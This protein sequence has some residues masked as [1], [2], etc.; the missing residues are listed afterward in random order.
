MTV[1]D[2]NTIVNDLDGNM[3]SGPITN[4]TLVAYAYD[5]RNR[6]LNVGGVTNT[7]D[8]M[9]NRIGQTYGTNSVAYTINPNSSLPQLLMRIKNGVTNYYVYGAGLLYQVTESAAATNTLTYHYDYR[10]STVALTDGTGTNV[11]DQIEYSAYATMT[12]RT[13]TNDTPFLFNGRYGVM[14][15]PN[16][17]LYM[18]ARYYNPYI[19]RFVNPDPSGF[20]GG[21]NFYA[22][23]NGNPVSMVDPGGLD[24]AQAPQAASWLAN[25]I[26]VNSSGAPLNPSN[27]FSLDIPE[28]PP[29]TGQLFGNGLNN[30]VTAMGNTVGLALYPPGWTWQNWNQASAPLYSMDTPAN[31]AA[32][33]YVEGALGVSGG[34]TALAGGIG[35][36]GAVGLPT[37][38]VAV[39]EGGFSLSP[40]HAAYGVGDTWVNAVGNS[41]FKMTVSGAGAAD[42]VAAPYFTVTGIPVLFPSA[43]TTTGIP[44]WSCVTA[45]SS[46]L[47]RG[48]GL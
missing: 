29:T 45:A 38:N 13:G 34:A 36:W 1:I 35:L 26:G 39:G 32:T 46:A 9:N 23:G 22:Y 24:A 14:T 30:T 17:L 19:C 37:M 33:P 5:A 44:A 31:P 21:L 3:T 4:D 12:I 48:W 11:T 18:R 42:T 6:L 7:Y 41:F 40:I 15:D 2:G 27:P 28:E 20:S 25:A 16:G 43:V 8:A 10:G 47:W